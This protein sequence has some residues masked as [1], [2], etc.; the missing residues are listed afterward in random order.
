M[1]SMTVFQAFPNALE[2]WEI[3]R[4]KYSTITGN[5]AVN[6]ATSTIHCIV[7]RG[8]STSPNPGNTAQN[9]ESDTLIYCQ[10]NELPT[11]DTSELVASYMVSDG[12]NI[13][14]IIDA[15]LGKNQENGI[16][17]HVELRLRQNGL[18]DEQ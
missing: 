8:D 17:E 5:V 11:T 7:D 4:V 10:P 6:G 18:D 14:A 3:G 1:L 13:Y 9:A 16:L 12:K 15:G 2:T